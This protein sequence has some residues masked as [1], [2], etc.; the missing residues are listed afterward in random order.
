MREW[1]LIIAVLTTSGWV[2]NV[3]DHKF[4]P[5]I[6]KYTQERQCKD[7]AYQIANRGVHKSSNYFYTAYC[8]ELALQGD[9]Q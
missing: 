9:T 7:L 2:N 4:N 3:V 1:I 6:G 8:K 5:T